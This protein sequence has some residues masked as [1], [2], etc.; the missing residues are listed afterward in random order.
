MLFLRMIIVTL[1]LYQLLHQTETEIAYLGKL[2]SD[3][4]QA[5]SRGHSPRNGV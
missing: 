4:V 2:M 3:V 5:V 1:N